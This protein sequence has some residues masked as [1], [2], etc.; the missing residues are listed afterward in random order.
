MCGQNIL[1]KRTLYVITVANI[2]MNMRINNDDC[3][4]G[5][6]SY[7]GNDDKNGNG[8]NDSDSSSSSNKND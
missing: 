5:G 4:D 2:V 7:N 8:N 3:L 6:D 1:Q